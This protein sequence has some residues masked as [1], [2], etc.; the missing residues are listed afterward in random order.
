MRVL[1]TRRISRDLLPY[2]APFQ[3]FVAYYGLFFNILVVLT[4]GFTAWIPSF[5]VENF[6]VAYVS[7]IL[8]A[9]LYIGHK[10]A[11]RDPLVSPLKADLDTGR[12]E[13]E[14]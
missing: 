7:L 5:S 6:F 3:P 2:I 9:V 13:V 8:F 1:K 10:L 11:Y 4:Q 12:L 14:N